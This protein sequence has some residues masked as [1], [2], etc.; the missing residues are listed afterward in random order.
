[1][2]PAFQLAYDD[3]VINRNPFAFPLTSVIIDDSVRIEALTPEQERVFL[4]FIENDKHFCKYYDGIY[5]LLKTE[6]RISE[7]CGLTMKSIDLD[8]RI[9]HIT[10]QLQRIG[11]E[12]TLQEPKTING[13]RDIPMSNTVYECCVRIVEKAKAL[14]SPTVATL[15]DFLFLDKEGK[16]L[17]A[18]HWEKYFD[19]II[20]KYNKKHKEKLPKVTPHVCRHT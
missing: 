8:N 6:V 1:L 15:S 10:H 20:T 7:F 5:F 12:Y 2:K 9:I 11:M 16:P 13:V 19:H 14:S 3:M 17:T 4:E 18:L